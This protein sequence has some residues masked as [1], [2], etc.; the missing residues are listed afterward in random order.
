MLRSTR[1][2]MRSGF[3]LSWR[4]WS[5]CSSSSLSLSFIFFERAEGHADHLPKSH[6][7]AKQQPDQIEPLSMQP[8]IG[9]LAQKEPQQNRRRNN[10][11]HLGI[12]SQRDE[13]IFLLRGIG[14]LRHAREL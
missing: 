3:V 1:G 8:V 10:K 14:R 5:R 6:H 13:R 11:S 12:A 4:R 2:T 7:C 9:Q